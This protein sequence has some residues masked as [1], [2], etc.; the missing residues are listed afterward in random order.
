[1]VVVDPEPIPRK[2]ALKLES[3]RDGIRRYVVALLA[4]A[5]LCHGHTIY[6]VSHV[7]IRGY[8]RT[9]NKT[10]GLHGGG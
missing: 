3:T 8:P 1:M 9:N 6:L 7:K 5:A 4:A 2:W 10:Y